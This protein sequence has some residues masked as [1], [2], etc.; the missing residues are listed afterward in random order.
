MRLIDYPEW[1]LGKLLS[2]RRGNDHDLFCKAP[3]FEDFPAP[4]ITVE[5]PEIGPSGSKLGKEYGAWGPGRIPTIKW[6]LSSSLDTAKV[7]E[8]LLVFEDPDAPLSH[9]NPH[10]IYA[11]VPASRSKIEQTDLE[12]MRKEGERNIVRG[13]FS[14][15]KNRRNIVYIAPRPPL[16]HGPHRYFFEVVALSEPLKLTK[17]GEAPSISELKT[18]VDG[19]V[20]GWGQWVGTFEST[21]DR[22]E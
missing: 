21:W 8:Y 15:G 5:A 9:S 7:K 20:A 16:G 3:A 4:N 1:F 6:S 11:E 18:L 10:G 17:N 13:G 19:K 14:V 2:G 22:H 12:L